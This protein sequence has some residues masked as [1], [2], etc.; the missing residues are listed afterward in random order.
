MLPKQ[1]RLVWLVC[2]AGLWLTSCFVHHRHVAPPGNVQNRPLLVATKQELIDRIHRAFDP[3]QS[4][5]MRA[6]M[7]ASVGKLYGGELTDYATVRTYVLFMRP[8]AIRVLGL[9]PVV[10]S[11]TIFDMVSTASDFRV[12]IPSKNRFIMG[13]NNAPPSSANALE[14]MRPAAFL[15]SMIIAPPAPSDTTLLEDD[16]D[17]S[18]A[19]YILFMADS[20]GGSLHLTRAIYFDRYT[21]GIVRQRTFAT[22]GN[23][24]GETRY[25]DWKPYGEISYPSVIQIQR[26]IE[27]YEVTM[28]LVD[29]TIN[30]PDMTAAKFVLAQPGGV[31]VTTLK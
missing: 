3:I 2:V 30:P 21:L 17:E 20:S 18:K 25:S 14:N 31:Q 15:Q 6:D 23:I 1:R 5:N 7:S 27:G 4:F 22:N 29:L 26:P 16:T 19:I 8:D 10:H 13:D 24:E 28:T 12:Y 11:A 9:D